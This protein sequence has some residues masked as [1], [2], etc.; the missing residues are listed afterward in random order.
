ML[1]SIYQGA[2]TL[3]KR[4]RDC[5]RAIEVSTGSGSDLDVKS[6]DCRFW[7]NGLIMFPLWRAAFGKAGRVLAPALSTTLV[8][9]A[10]A[11]LHHT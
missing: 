1:R 5:Q 7:G 6:C 10:T 2:F 8:L 11:D 4:L 3:A 9:A